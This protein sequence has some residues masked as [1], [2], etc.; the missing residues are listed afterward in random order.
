MRRPRGIGAR[1]DA[2]VRQTLLATGLS[3][4]DSKFKELGRLGRGPAKRMESYIS[5]AFVWRTEKRF[6]H[7]AAV[8]GSRN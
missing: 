2:E 3:L 5:S 6:V 1:L 7:T 4:D 8:R